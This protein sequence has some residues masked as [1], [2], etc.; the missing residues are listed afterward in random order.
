MAL[1]VY[2]P[3]RSRESS[4]IVRIMESRKKIVITISVHMLFQQINLLSRKKEREREKERL[5][6]CTGHWQ[7]ISK[8][9]ESNAVKFSINAL[10]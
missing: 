3:A 6:E 7:Q 5:R 10:A 9:D 1:T 4:Y 8:M 2:T